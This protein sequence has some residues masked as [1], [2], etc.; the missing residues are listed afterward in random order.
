MI[1]EISLAVVGAG[2]AGCT[3]AETAALSGT[4]VLLIDKKQ[5]IGTPVQ[6]GGFLPAAKELQYMM[7]RAILPITLEDIPGHCIRHH[8]SLQRFYA[9]SGR[10]KEFH[11]AA[12]ILDR[13]AFDR[14]L[15]Y[16]AAKAGATILPA[17]RA[18]LI[19][20][21][22]K[23]SGRFSGSVRPK[24]LVGADGSLSSIAKSI[25]AN[26]K[27]VGICLEYEMVDVNIDHEAAEMYFGTK[28]APGGYAWIIPLGHDAANVG[29]GI[30]ASFAEKNKLPKLLDD[31]IINHPVASEKLRKGEILGVMRGLVPTGGAPKEIQQGKLLLAGDAAGH[32]MATSGGGIP[33]AMVAGRIAG[34]V[35]SWF[36]K[37]ECPIEE[38]S[39]RIREEFGHELEQS[40]QIRRLVDVVMRSNKL[41]EA[42]ISILSPAQIKSM[43]RAQIPKELKLFH[44]RLIKDRPGHH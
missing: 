5:A 30:R 15:A 20:D 26:T 42:L 4:N 22:L 38:Y 21:H 33:L 41:I 40:V 44:E 27:E 18:K 9:P 2:P 14:N 37:G 24:I 10:N 29:V 12:R 25:G 6:C 3:A 1:R 23:L 39:Y 36:L 16:R 13:C 19:E 31:F 17:T 8:T 35:A 11:V 28:W 7:P 43:M 32:V 34:E